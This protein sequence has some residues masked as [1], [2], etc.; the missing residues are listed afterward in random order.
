MTI[1]WFKTEA[2][3]NNIEIE[4]TDYYKHPLPYDVCGLF[5]FGEDQTLIFYDEDH[6]RIV[7]ILN[8]STGKTLKCLKINLKTGYSDCFVNYKSRIGESISAKDALILDLNTFFANLSKNNL[9]IYK[10]VGHKSNP[11]RIKKG[12]KPIYEWKLVDIKPK[13]AE[14]PSLGGTHASPRQHDRRGH[15]RVIKKTGKKIWV[16]PCVVGSLENGRIDHVYRLA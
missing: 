16:K 1:V 11:K 2:Q 10:K 14:R 7:N 6:Y 5:Q 13:A 9:P 12:K 15:W 4:T 3:Y 8:L